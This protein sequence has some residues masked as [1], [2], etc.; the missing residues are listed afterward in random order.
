MPS[1]NGAQGLIIQQAASI[2][3]PHSAFAFAREMEKEADW[4]GLQYLYKAGYDPQSR[5]TFFEKLQAREPAKR[6]S[7]LL[8]TQQPTA[9]RIRET[10]QNIARYLPARAQAFITSGDFLAVK[11]RLAAGLKSKTDALFVSDPRPSLLR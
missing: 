6:S 8:A 11:A 1:H 10:Q 9:D 4:L 5:V 7:A 2:G 3:V